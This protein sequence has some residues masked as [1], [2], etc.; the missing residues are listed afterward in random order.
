MRNQKPLNTESIITQINACV[1]KMPQLPPTVGKVMAI[2]N[3]PQSSPAELNRAIGLDPVLTAKVLRLINSAY[4]GMKQEI[5]SLV[6]AVVMLGMN[7][8]KNLSLSSAIMSTLGK[9]RRFGGMNPTDFWRHCLGVGA[10][11]RM[12]AKARGVPM[13]EQE[14][15]FIMGLLHDLG[16]IPLNTCFSEEYGHLTSQL[17]PLGDPLF[18]REKETFG[19]DHAE[20]GR[21]I[22]E[23]WNIRSKVA[24]AVGGHHDPAMISDPD[25][26][27]IAMVA[28][29]D[30]FVNF[31]Q[32]G[33]SKG[34]ETMGIRPEIHGLLGLDDDFFLARREEL[35]EEI[36]RAMVFLEVA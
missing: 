32:T 1:K 7:T 14:E 28:A 22:L 5:T 18:H 19:M 35:L 21:M 6:R 20:V 16:K 13:G 29:A 15:Y 17:D 30:E 33:T 10:V 3:D 34:E 2:C 36:S 23:H 27:H 25:K 24:D 31:C 4:Y 26:D 8:I 12:I 9:G 11:C